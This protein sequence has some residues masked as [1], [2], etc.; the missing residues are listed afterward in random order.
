VLDGAEAITCRP[1]DLLSPEM[2]KLTEELLAL[3]KEKNIPLSDDRIDDVLTYALFPQIGLKFLQNRGDASAFEPVPTL[4]DVEDSK[5]APTVSS[6]EASVYTVSVA[7]QS[8]VVQVSEGGDVSHI[9][10]VTNTQSASAQTSSSPASSAGEKLPSPLAGN[11]F[12]ILVS[13]GQQVNEGDTVMILEAMKMETEISA[14]KSG[15]IGS[16][17]VKEGDSVKVGQSLL[18]L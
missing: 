18:T 17:D 15:V 1:A 4:N 16:I 3:S 9:Q 12:K 7:G 8:F 10:P 14:P 13:P 5:P 6:N 2:D 11:I